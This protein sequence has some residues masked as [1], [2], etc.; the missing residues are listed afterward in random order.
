VIA[1]AILIG[2]VAGYVF[3]Q[4]SKPAPRRSS[5]RPVRLGAASET[6][7]SLADLIEAT[8][9]AAL[10]VDPRVD[11]FDLVDQLTSDGTPDRLTVRVTDPKA[12]PAASLRCGDTASL[13]LPFE[14]AVALVPLYGPLTLVLDS[15]VYEVDGTKDRHALVRELSRRQTE[16]MREALARVRPGT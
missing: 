2:L 6:A 10:R 9:A 13:D 7:R 12:V 1:V 5:P 8:R 15:G 16:R 4:R 11:G 14:L 3:G